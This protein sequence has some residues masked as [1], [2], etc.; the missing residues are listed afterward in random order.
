M[1]A[2]GFTPAPR[3]SNMVWV[4]DIAGGV[5]WITTINGGGN[6]D[7]SDYAFQGKYAIDA[8]YNNF[9]FIDTTVPGSCPTAFMSCAPVVSNVPCAGSQG[10]V[11]VYGDILVRAHEGTH[12]VPY[13]DLTRAC[14][15]AGNEIQTVLV[16]GFDTDGDSFTL[17]FWGAGTTIPITR[18]SNNTAAGVAAA[19]QGGAEDRT[20]RSPASTR[21]ASR[22][23]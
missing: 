17:S 16:N 13:G 10:D 22:S 4:N 18:G 5:G 23:R 20:S 2:Y 14:E 9:R 12:S 19:L 6:G 8:E 3:T 21:T 7:A 11:I 15:V 1:N